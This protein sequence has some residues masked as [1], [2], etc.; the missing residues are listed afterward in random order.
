MRNS[1]SPTQVTITSILAVTAIAWLSYDVYATDQYMRGAKDGA[2]QQQ[3]VDYAWCH[4]QIT[5]LS[6]VPY[7]QK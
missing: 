1:M 4:T 7:E 6:Q 2:I 3:A 5:A